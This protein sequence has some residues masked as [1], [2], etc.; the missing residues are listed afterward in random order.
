M[1]LTKPGIS[2]RFARGRA[3]RRAQMPFS[4]IAVLL[5]VVSSASV[6]LL[7]GLDAQKGSARIPQ[8][9][10]EDMRE[11]MDATVEDVVRIA[12][13]SA[14]ESIRGTAV[15]NSS[16]LQE[17]FLSS[18]ND[19][20]ALAYPCVN[21][22]LRSSVTHNI[23]LSFLLANL[24]ESFAR[25]GEDITSWQG[26]SVPAYFV[27]TGNYSIEVS[28][29][30]GRLTRTVELDQ[31]VYVPLPLLSYKLER[32]S[33]AASPMGEVESIVQYELAALAQDRV[34]RGYGSEAKT[35]AESTQV[36]LTSEDVLRAVNLAILLEELRYFQSI[37]AFDGDLGA[38]APPLSGLEGEVDPADLFLSSYNEGGIDLAAVVGQALYARADSIVLKWMD[39]LGLID[40]VNLG[41]STLEMGEDNLYA[42]ID[43]LT[44][45]DHD[46]TVMA[47]YIGSAMAEAGFQEYDY[48]W[49]CYGGGD[50][51]VNLPSF[52]I[53]VLDDLGKKVY[54]T[55]QGLYAIDMPNM[56]V[57][58]SPAWG[59]LRE[60]YR[61]ETHSIAEAMR[62]Y[63]EAVAYGVASNC[64]LSPIG[65][66]LDPTD[67]RTY[68]EEIDTQL[69]EA[70]KDGSAWIQPAID[71]ANEVRQVR[72]GLAQ[73]AMDFIDRHWMEILKV[74]SSL[75]LACW[76]LSG[77]LVQEELG[78]LPNFSEQCMLTARNKTYMSLTGE[79]WGVWNAMLSE[80]REGRID[81]LLA[82]LDLALSQK[83][84]DSGQIVSMIA[85]AMTSTTG[86]GL[87]TALMVKDTMEGFGDSL[88]AQGGA[89]EVPIA[90]GGMVLNLADGQQRTE[91]FTASPS[92]MVLSDDGQVGS[93]E[94]S[95]QMP[96]Q[97]DRSNTSYPNRHVT[98]LRNMASTPY[99]TQWNVRYSG[100]MEIVVRSEV[101]AVDLPCSAILQL[102]GCFN[103]VAFSG[104]SLEGV[105]YA[106]TATLRGDVQNLLDGLYGMITSA[107]ES[108]GHLSDNLFVL[109]YRLI[110]DLLSCSTGALEALEQVLASGTDSLEGIITG[111]MGDAIGLLADGATAIVGGTTIDLHVLGLSVAVVFAPQ[112][113][114]LTGTEDRMRID[115]SQSFAGATMS[116]SLRVLRLSGGEH[117]IAAS[118]SLEADDWSVDLTVDP[119]TKVY[120]HQVE[121]RGYMGQHMIELY[122]PEVERVQ[123]VTL[124][125]SDVPGL[126][127]ALRS[128]PSP[129]P[130]TKWH[131]DAGMEMSFNILDRDTL[132][133]NEVEL[134]PKGADRSRE[135]VEIYNPGNAAVDLGG[136]V[137]A[138]SRGDQHREV[139]SGTVPAHGYYVHQ[140]TGQ[141]LD[142][143]DVKGFPLQESVTLLDRNGKRVDSAPWLKDLNDD[144][145]T[146]Q[147][148]YDGS[149]QWELRD[150]SRGA[151][152]GFVLLG[153]QNLDALLAM[154]VECFQES[155][156]EE[157]SSSFDMSTLRDI[158]AGALL[159]MT[160][161]M[162][163]SVERTISTLRFY[164]ELGLDDLTGS[165]GMGVTMGLEYNGKAVRDC[166]EWFI[167]AI[168]EVMN[169][170]LNPLAAGARAE[171]PMRTLADNVFLQMGAYMTVGTPDL[172]RGIAEAKLTVMGTIKVSLG[173]LGIVNGGSTTEVSFGLVASGMAGTKISI[174]VDQSATACYDVWLFRG[175]LR[176]A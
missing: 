45:G 71:K 35:G 37:G 93:L 148:T 22:D 63:V 81:P 112:D 166:L 105:E 57:L 11:T 157:M 172:I 145:R 113:T 133:I 154:V 20:L 160:D 83:V 103:I 14:V 87:L 149:S 30:E 56:D 31:D 67:G 58:S 75:A 96:W 8:E 70:F 78:G 55:F 142:N 132:I 155:F 46:Q 23:S 49:Y 24:Q 85:D 9:K 88:T 1:T 124:S 29:P 38:I 7:Y 97:Y 32:M 128:L 59:D 36:M 13:S 169:D 53:P 174:G 167:D 176:T 114:A 43:F 80:L 19:S 48:R 125:L 92:A 116:S 134:N 136:Y 15:L 139:L 6:A 120:E 158:V 79:N 173:T 42:V 34:L 47:D 159:R 168:G 2:N 21:G 131:V 162:L 164:M 73:A 50:I 65:L 165:A 153:E 151:S 16:A 147:R 5:L 170:P 25:M 115:V 140:F 91:S 60:S 104:W 118:M 123:K 61:S 52:Q 175:S 171:V 119:L 121:L 150:G 100:A 64:H 33:C 111:Y 17:R 90:S 62:S 102:Q 86:L 101:G 28:C 3:D 152:N 44:G 99:L 141:A 109:L 135:W 12:Y 130:G 107:V 41:E 18:F 161:R 144:G 106:P 89:F 82:K 108:M 4:I 129:V 110:S 156:E 66:E 54:M 95:I 74:N 72:E 26:S 122:A 127:D 138:T 98:D 163:D 51:I 39:Y 143:G 84:E 126:G 117:T 137:L 68:L 40:L 77:V 76:D 146:W 10:L 69:N 94:V 27:L